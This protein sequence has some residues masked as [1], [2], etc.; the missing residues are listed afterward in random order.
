MSTIEQIVI[1][2]GVES[3]GISAFEFCNQLKTVV[4]PDSVTEL[5]TM[6]FSNCALLEN[7]VLSD[8][9]T[10]IGA[11]AFD[12]TP[13]YEDTFT[14]DAVSWPDGVLYI[15]NYLIEANNL[16]ANDYTIK[17]GTL[18]IADDA[19]LGNLSIKSI[20]IPDSVQFI[21]REAF[22][23]TDLQ[24]INGLNGFKT[25]GESS[26]YHCSIK[27]L[28]IPDSVVRIDDN[29][30]S[31]CELL[32]NITMPN[33]IDVIHTAT[34]KGCKSL[35]SLLIPDGVRIIDYDAFGD[36]ISLKSVCIP[37]SVTII[38]PAFYGN[39]VLSD[40]YYSGSQ[41][42]W[43]QIE[44]SEWNSSLLAA[45][46]HFAIESHTHIPITHTQ[47]STCIVQGYTITTCL[48]CGDQLGFEV[49]PFA[50]HRYGEWVTVN[51]P[52]T[53]EKGRRE[54]ICTVC[55]VAK[56]TEDIP[57]LE[58]LVAKDEPSGITVS[59]DE[60]TYE[61]DAVEL[62]V[63]E[64]F[65]GSQYLTQSYGR[66]DT[67]NIKTYINGEEAQPGQP[68]TVRIPQPEGYDPNNIAVF[69]VNSKTGQSE[70]IEDVRVEDGYIVFTA[71][72]F[73]VYIV[74]D[75]SSAVQADPEPDPNLC[76]WCGKVHS[77]FFGGLIAFFH[78][79]FARLFGAK[80]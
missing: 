60:G 12:Q 27:V 64:V 7:V 71:T 1:P 53:T 22:Y 25:I 62:R 68:V 43:E 57:M 48:E 34:F 29:A 5:K 28:S 37:T 15:D 35:K 2:E 67:W 59:F 45:K 6:T 42:Q 10:S 24:I 13:F 8:N 9:L 44:I 23:N 19:F 65:D 31:D 36:C 52:T 66:I 70:R 39:E 80:F 51:E 18:G 4:I 26:F 50:D 58:Q 32:T 76:P 21:G 78:R 75:E 11:Y 47:P 3:I 69:H 55:G 14:G 49:L 30:F 77:G 33:G 20:T 61:E 73:S 17:D 16:I 38:N 72:S 54:R 40:V 56:E 74:V 41:E 79:I 46:V 63:E